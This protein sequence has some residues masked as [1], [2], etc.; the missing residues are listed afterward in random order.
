MHDNRRLNGSWLPGVEA[1]E[2]VFVTGDG[3]LV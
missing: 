3:R 2:G 1:T